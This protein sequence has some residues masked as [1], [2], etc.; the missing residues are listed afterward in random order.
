MICFVKDY[1]SNAHC[2]CTMFYFNLQAKG[3]TLHVFITFQK[4]SQ[5]LTVSIYQVFTVIFSVAIDCL[6]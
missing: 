5:N 2:S 1:N 6:I 3:Q 4:M